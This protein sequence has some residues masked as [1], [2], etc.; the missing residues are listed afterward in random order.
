MPEFVLV[1]YQCFDYDVSGEPDGEWGKRY[2]KE[3]EENTIKYLI[4]TYN[5]I[6]L[7]FYL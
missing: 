5:G 4:P 6:F 1:V 3:Q 7:T 2:K